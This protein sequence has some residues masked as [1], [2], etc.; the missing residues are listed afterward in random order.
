MDRV[1]PQEFAT[2]V[3]V[4]TVTSASYGGMRL[5]AGVVGSSRRCYGSTRAGVVVKSAGL[6]VR[7]CGVVCREQCY[8]I[9]GWLIGVGRALSPRQR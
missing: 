4:P 2:V 3:F 1:K 7:G 6:G 5:G 9:V 8:S